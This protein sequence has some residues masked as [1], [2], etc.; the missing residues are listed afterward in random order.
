MPLY[1]SLGEVPHKRHCVFEKPGGGMYTEHLMGNLG[2]T[3]LSSLVYTIRRPTAVLRTSIRREVR[4]EEDPDRTLRMRHLRTHRLPPAGPSPV[5]DRTPL[6][7]NA[8]VAISI[9]R[10]AADDEFFYRNAMGDEIVY[11][12]EGKGV[13]E[14]QMGD[15]AIRSGDHVVVP[16]GIFHRYRFEGEAI[17]LVIESRGHVRTPSRY[18]N[19][20]GQLMEHAPFC[21]RD[22]RRPESLPVHD[23]EGEFTIVVKKGDAFHDVVM[24]HHPRD[25]VGWDATTTRGR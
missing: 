10:P 20:H 6:L 18:R 21:E 24:S 9:A 23:E 13:L 25:A 3:G 17:L 22:I 8:D 19:Q 16:R 12:T 11:V 7:Y 4:W 1:H 14:S 15:L 2:F 5:L